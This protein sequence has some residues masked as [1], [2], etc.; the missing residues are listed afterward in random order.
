MQLILCNAINT[1]IGRIQ[2]FKLLQNLRNSFHQYFTEMKLHCIIVAYFAMMIQIVL[3]NGQFEAHCKCQ[4]IWVFY[5]PTGYS[6]YPTHDQKGIY[7]LEKSLKVGTC[8]KL[9]KECDKF[10]GGKN[11]VF[12]AKLVKPNMKVCISNTENEPIINAQSYYYY[13]HN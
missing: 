6:Y 4:P 2:L 8:N 1:L 13:R 5:N 9:R 10:C 12:K 11:S 3:A 7:Y